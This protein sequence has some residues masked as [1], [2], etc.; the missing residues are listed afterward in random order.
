MDGRV[1]A[2]AEVRG[3]Y[4]NRTDALD[5]GYSDSQLRSAV[6]ERHLRRLRHG[7]CAPAQTYDDLGPEQRHLVLARSVVAGMSGRVALSHRSGSVAHGHD[8]W[9]WDMSVVDGTRLDEGAGRRE[10][11]VIH[12]E[13]LV[14]DDDVVDIG[15]LPVL[16]EERVTVESAL[17]LDG[18]AGVCTVDSALRAGRLNR[19]DLE[20]PC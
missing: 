9:G 10:A 4:F 6:R 1:L 16:T 17:V 12:H 7:T 15:G 3:G 5:C 20:R 19:E 18:E 8:Q 13:G 11:G 14:S 2:I